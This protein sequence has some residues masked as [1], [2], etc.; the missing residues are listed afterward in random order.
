MPQ[1]DHDLTA[2]ENLEEITL[3]DVEGTRDN[4]TELFG[5]QLLTSYTI[6]RGQ[7]LSAPGQAETLCLSLSDLK[8]GLGPTDSELSSPIFW[9]NREREKIAFLAGLALAGF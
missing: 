3:K 6:L 9:T 2:R 4:A 5:G 1:C 7:V 8:V